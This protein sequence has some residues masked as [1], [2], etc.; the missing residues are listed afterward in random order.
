MA[1]F[2]HYI[3]NHHQDIFRYLL[4]LIAI[5]LILIW[6]PIG[7]K[8]KYEFAKGKVWQYEEELYAPFDF[9]IKKAADEIEGEKE[10]VL[11]NFIPYFRVDLNRY[12]E[13]EKEYNIAFNKALEIL[14]QEKSDSIRFRY[15]KRN[16]KSIKQY[17]HAILA[18]VYGKGIVKEKEVKGIPK[19]NLLKKNIATLAKSNEFYTEAK[20][21]HHI[22]KSLEIEAP[23]TQVFMTPIL[24]ELIQ[25]NIHL[26]KEV[27]D[28]FKYELTQNITGTKGI[29]LKDE[30]IISKGL[31]INDE[32]YQILVS[33]RDAYEQ[34]TGELRNLFITYLGY[35]IVICVC[36]SIVMIHLIMNKQ[37]IFK[38]NRNLMFILFI[39]VLFTYIIGWVNR[40]DAVSIY[41]IPVCII[42]IVIRAFFDIRTALFT[43]I[44]VILIYGFIVPQSFE[45]VFLNLTTGVFTVFSIRRLHY[46]SQF[47]KTA[48]IMLSTYIGVY[49]GTI[50]IQYGNIEKVD[51]TMMGWLTLNVVFTLLA[52]PLISIFEKLFGLV[53]EI[54]IFELSDL[55]KPLLKELS[56][57]SPG[58]FQH[59]LQVANLAEAGA[60]AIDANPLLARVG[61]LYHDIGKMYSPTYFIENQI[62]GVNPHNELSFQ[63]SAK[64]IIDHVIN[65][66]ELAKKHHLPDIIIDF[67]RTHHG[68]SRVEYF[69]QSFLRDFPEEEVDES[70]FRYPGTIPFSKETGILMLADS[71][72]AASRSLKKPTEEDIDKLVEGIVNH[73]VKEE[74][75]I[76]CDMTFNDITRLKNLFK[77]M[78]K[79]IY[80]VRISYPKESMN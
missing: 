30:K 28:N 16:R 47:Y 72:E 73:K 64:I 43:Q 57:K 24:E 34:N 76:N 77:K 1:K 55:N 63:D 42:P 46:R 70:K 41:V 2:N 78:L 3:I 53:S 74:Q 27:T 75:L 62:T 15:I 71:V 69:Y 40:F 31:V 17:G 50:F 32:K 65:G 67:I 26:D 37:E 54:S 5:V 20:A 38:S 56:I 4:I 33:L 51:L 36:L 44:S 68:T 19:F 48:L 9:P 80:H 6:L 7:G 13:V 23:S 58:T 79:S 25:A 49:L 8:F 66:V 21:I 11:K 60:Y 12:L 14:Q 45:F 18:Y 35:F 10:K 61:A 39:I 59:S 29:V 22:K 52:F